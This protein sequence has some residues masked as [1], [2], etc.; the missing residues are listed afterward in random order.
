MNA[1]RRIAELSTL[2][3]IASALNESPD[4]ASALHTSLE[5]LVQ[6]MGLT[7][8]WIFLCD[9]ESET[10]PA[11][12]IHTSDFQLPPALGADRAALLKSSGCACQDL[13][14]SGKFRKS[15]NI[16]ECSRIED[17]LEQDGDAGGLRIHAS[18]PIHARDRVIGI[19]NVASP[20]VHRFSEE[21]LQLMTAVGHQ[22]GLAA[23]RA[24]LYD[25]IRSRRI[26]EQ[27][28]LLKLSNA[29]IA[30]YDLQAIVDQVVHVVAEVLST[31]ACA[32]MLAGAEGG[33]EFRASVGWNLSLFAAGP[34]RFDRQGPAGLAYY[35][36]QPI[37]SDDLETDRR[38][39]FDDLYRHLEFRSVLAVPV[40]HSG[41]AIGALVVN[42][43][44]PRQFN[45]DDIRLMQLMANQAAIAIETVRLQERAAAERQLRKEL[46]LARDIQTSFL[47]RQLPRLA[48]WDFGAY[49][50][51]AREIGGDFYDF[52]P[53]RDPSQRPAGMEGNFLEGCNLLGLVIADV[54]D[55]GVP[56]ALF[57]ALS[58]TLVRAVTISGRSPAEAIQRANELIRSDSRSDQFITLFYAALDPEAATLRFVNAGHNPPM[59]V[60]CD[61]E[62]I[63]TL[64]APGTVL[65][66]LDGI[67]L[68]EA[69]THFEPGDILLMYTDGVIDALNADSEEFGMERLAKI[70]I[71]NCHLSAEGLVNKIVEELGAFVGDREAFDD[72]T[73]V[74]VKRVR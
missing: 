45:D 10:Q 14:R 21:D 53:L 39:N 8:G 58:R 64:R 65:G 30:S 6:L 57:M 62:T 74:A 56:A 51:A 46:Q 41:Q 36:G 60:R 2:N 38:F 50:A 33:I 49:Y 40:T 35:T 29:L 37:R 68:T 27:D 69:E 71:E 9:L 44:T 73:M 28:A 24:H 5:R 18:A 31:D 66:I 34:P 4:L 1:D 3:Q 20:A 43:R 16:V 47:P 70:M 54:S 22:I 63:F 32:L 25:L 19:L 17:A 55:K 13:F 59:L 26:L 67:R 48:G 7:T 42:T 15:V 52:I 23:E 61:P 72:M 12:L 11:Q